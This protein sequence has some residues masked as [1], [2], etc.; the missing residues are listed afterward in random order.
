MVDNNLDQD[1]VTDARGVKRSCRAR[2]LFDGRFG[3]WTPEQDERR[4]GILREARH[5]KSGREKDL[6]E[7]LGRDMHSEDWVKDLEQLYSRGHLIV[8]R[9]VWDG[10]LAEF[11]E[12]PDKEKVA[13][14]T[15]NGDHFAGMTYQQ[16]TDIANERVTSVG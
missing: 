9:K 13:R 7:R 8:Q 3:D 15:G 12:L 2:R 14:L 1:F 5:N 16:A 10:V 4:F 6:A 11:V